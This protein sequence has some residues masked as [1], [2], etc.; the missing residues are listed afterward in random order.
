MVCDRLLGTE[1]SLSP[2]YSTVM[3]SGW[4]GVLTITTG[5]IWSVR[6]TLPGAAGGDE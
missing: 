2:P 5:A 1:R 4:L 6:N 3:L